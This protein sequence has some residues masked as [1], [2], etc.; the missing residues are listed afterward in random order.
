MPRVP[1]RLRLAAGAAFAALALLAA[2]GSQGAQTPGRIATGAAGW[3]GFVDGDRRAVAVGQRMI[4]VLRYPS[5]ADRIVEAGGH[6]GE[7][8]MRRWTAAA[9]GSSSVSRRGSK[10]S[11]RARSGRC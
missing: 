4:V 6:A 1:D 2:G 11:S 3:S 8:Q 10:G 9:L 5:L 7:S